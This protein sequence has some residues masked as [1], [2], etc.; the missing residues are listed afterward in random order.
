MEVV[1]PCGVTAVTALVPRPHHARVVQAALG[2]HQR[3]RVDRVHAPGDRGDD[4]LGL[5]SK[6]AW[7]AS[8]RSPSTPNSST[9]PVGA[10]QNPLADRVTLR[11]VVVDRPAPRRLVLL[12]EVRAERSSALTPEVPTWL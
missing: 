5:E 11:I 4:V 6:I 8:S 10:L 9:Q 1:G 3:R 12:G 2:D 7:I